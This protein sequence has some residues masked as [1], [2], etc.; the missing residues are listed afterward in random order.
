MVMYYVSHQ[1]ILVDVKLE[2]FY[3]GHENVDPDIEL[4]IINEERVT[5]VLL[6]YHLALLLLAGNIS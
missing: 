4:E 3:A 6:H 1:T 2:R 5:D